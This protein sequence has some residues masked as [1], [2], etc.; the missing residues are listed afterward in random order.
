MEWT[1]GEV[2]SGLAAD[3]KELHSAVFNENAAR[4][5]AGLT[6][7]VGAIAFSYAYFDKNYV[8]LQVV[9][10]FFFVEFLIRVRSASSTARW[11]WSRA[12]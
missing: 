5:A 8:P 11:A 9:T 2:I 7:V 6:M 12:L 1:F 4:A 3:G 10:T